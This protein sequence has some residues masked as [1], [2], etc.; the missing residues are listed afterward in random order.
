M[1][2]TVVAN[3]IEFDGYQIARISTGV[4]ATVRGR[5]EDALAN[6]YEDSDETPSEADKKNDAE[7]LDGIFE[8]AKAKAEAG[9]VELSELATILNALK[10]VDE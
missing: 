7:V 8:A 4:P 10:K 3:V 1:T 9:M 6:A 5:F 2:V